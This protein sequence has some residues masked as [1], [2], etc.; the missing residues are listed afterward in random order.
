MTI[1]EN[2]RTTPGLALT[3]V[4]MVALPIGLQWVTPATVVIPIVTAVL[5]LVLSRLMPGA[6]SHA[7]LRIWIGSAIVRWLALVAAVVAQRSL[8]TVVLGGDGQQYLSR[9]LY[10][11]ASGFSLDVSPIVEFGTYDVGPYYYFATVIGGLGQNLIALQMT[12]AAVSSL[13]PPLTYAMAHRLVPRHAMW[14]GIVL[15]LYPTAMVFAVL[16]LL[17]DPSVVLATVTAFCAIVY[18]I[19]DDAILAP[20]R[21]A[22][23]L[24]LIL[25]S[26]SY[27][28]LSRYYSMLFLGLAMLVSVGF[29]VAWRR[30]RPRRAL[31]QVAV[32]WV[33]AE[34]IFLPFGWP[35]SP[36]MLSSSAQSVLD[37]A[38]IAHRATDVQGADEPLTSP[39]PRRRPG[40]V[41]RERALPQL[42][43]S[44]R[45]AGGGRSDA[46]DGAVVSPSTG[47]HTRDGSRNVGM[48]GAAPTAVKVET[49]AYQA[50]PE[51]SGVK[52]RVIDVSRKLLGPFVW[53]L[54]PDLSLR[55]VMVGDYLLY[56]G[57]IL[58]YIAWPFMIVGVVWTSILTVRGRAPLMLGCLAVF[59][60]LYLALYVGVNLSF[61][62]RDALLPFLLI[63]AAGGYDVIRDWR[64][65]P[66]GYG[67]Y[68]LG[69]VGLAAAHLVARARL[70]P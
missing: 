59:A 49:V 17:K 33:L 43:E 50:L 25:A 35:P 16:D 42:S 14:I 38:D 29:L 8:G 46:G 24:F 44:L 67:V 68:W 3:F 55:T 62:Q 22:T 64:A 10:L 18:L 37:A 52:G 41:A 56:P 15:A 28:H 6:S 32:V 70:A 12:N 30:A 21:R 4:A 36:A 65:W 53:V 69:L 47:L 2:S 27:L 26:L 7:F 11:A 60:G 23:L 54:P 19:E 66:W 63:L 5:A 34:G 9:A 61:R 40:I 51:Q 57:M 48:K 1:R 13:V 58:W 20:G 45:I 39:T 31:M